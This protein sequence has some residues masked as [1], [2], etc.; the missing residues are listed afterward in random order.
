MKERQKIKGR[1]GEVL[2]KTKGKEYFSALVK[3][4]WEIRKEKIRLWDEH[5]ET[6]NK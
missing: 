1:G 4:G 5:Q 6:L 2:L 3:R